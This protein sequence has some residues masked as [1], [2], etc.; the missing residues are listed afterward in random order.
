MIYC[1]NWMRYRSDNFIFRRNLY[2]NR[3]GDVFRTWAEPG[4]GGKSLVHPSC[5]SMCTLRSMKNDTD[6]MQTAGA[7]QLTPAVVQ[8]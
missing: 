7:I 5:V 1:E 8:W 6:N 3:Y 2:G 4:W